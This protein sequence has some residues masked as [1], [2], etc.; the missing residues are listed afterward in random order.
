MADTQVAKAAPETKAPLTIVQMLNSD[1]FKT[2]VGMALPKHLTPDRF[3]RMCLTA[4][5]RT[6]KLMKCTQDSVMNCMMTLSQ[7]GLEPDGR[8][9]HLIPFENRRDNC[10]ECT[11]I[12][13]YKGLVQLA[14]RS[15][16]VATIHADVVCEGDIF[17]YSLGEV[18]KHVPWFLRRDA[19]KPDE[20]GDVY[21]IF[22][23]VKNKDG[24]TKAEVM[25]ALEVEAIRR[26]SK[27]GESG[28]WKTDTNEMRKKTAFKRLTKWIVLSPEFRDALDV[29]DQ[30]VITLSQDEY[31]KLTDSVVSGSKVASLVESG[32]LTED[33][34]DD[35][36]DDGEQI[37][38]VARMNEA[39]NYLKA[40]VGVAHQVSDV[41]AGTALFKT[42]TN[43]PLI[44]TERRIDIPDGHHVVLVTDDDYMGQIKNILARSSKKAK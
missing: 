9:A 12:I 1:T 4:V 35:G 15:G 40:Q 8:L 7:V 5:R 18:T 22:A 17:E 37:D 44:L 34:G 29:D 41:E 11:L 43:E 25:S 24:T 2:Q 31:R 32:K 33:P 21:A 36:D 38:T 16:L 42:P 26:R 13:D 27:S 23:M 10:V 20:P 30:E 14:L 28:P 3:A 6:P 19:D 39:V